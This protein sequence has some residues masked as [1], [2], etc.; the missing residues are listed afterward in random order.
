MDDWRERYRDKVI[1]PEQ[2][3]AR[4]E[5]GQVV[6][7]GFNISAPRCFL[8]ALGRRTDELHGVTLYQ[9]LALSPA[10]WY[11]DGYAGGV[12]VRSGYL[13]A[14]SRPAVEWGVVDVDVMTVWTATKPEHGAGRARDHMYPDV[15]VVSISPPD[16]DGLVSFG[17]Q[18][19]YHK[20]WVERAK[21][22]IGEVN[23]NYIRTG[24][25]NSLSVD[26]FDLLIEQPETLPLASFARDAGGGDASTADTIGRL[27]AGLVQ[28]GD[29][30]QIGFGQ[31]SE[32]VVGALT[33]KNDLGFHAEIMPAGAIPLIQAGNLTGARKAIDRDRHVA[34]GLLLR[35]EDYAYVDG[36]PAFALREAHYTNNPS[37]IAQI[38]N[39][40]AINA[41]LAVDLTGQ[42]SAEA[43]GPQ[44]YS[45][46]AGQLDFQIGA[47]LSPGGRG[48]TVLPATAR[49]G[50]A[51]RIVAQF[52]E[53]QVISVPRTFADFVVTEFGVAS[54]QGLTQRGRAA[55][56]I[57]VAHPSAREELRSAA[58]RLF[59]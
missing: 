52:P 18:V 45:G 38:D 7:V 48:I 50:Q 57:E 35:S 29:C 34:T 8:G 43:F 22:A 37:V 59:G 54:L 25:D 15:A 1:T 5:S 44:M 41:A 39:F 13:S 30:I 16:A 23:V 49:G 42:V 56:L 21:I 2:A 51:S 24:G 19:W 53:G 4:I 55:A 10:P 11:E 3:A 40:V 17:S 46:V 47:M 58:R 32:A 9:H 14:F 26:A 36:N 31:I 28:D 20:R 12:Q 6:A 27:V 33:D